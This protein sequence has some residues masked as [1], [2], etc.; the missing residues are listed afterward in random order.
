[1]FTKLTLAD[2]QQYINDQIEENHRLEYKAAGSLVKTDKARREITKDVSAMANADGGLVIY[3]VSEHPEY[4]HLPEK[5]DP[6]DRAQISKE[7]LEHNINNIQPPI[8]GVEVYPIPVS[9]DDPNLAIYVVEI[10]QSDTAHQATDCKYYYRFNFE[11]EPMTD[12]QVRDVMGR[13]KHPKIELSFQFRTSRISLFTRHNLLIT[14]HNCGRIYAQHVSCIVH[15]PM[16]LSTREIEPF[17]RDLTIIDGQQ[18]RT[19]QDVNTH[20]D[21]IEQWVND[22]DYQPR[23]YHSLGPSWFRPI[24]PKMSHQWVH[25]LPAKFSYTDLPSDE[26]IHWE[27]YADNALPERGSTSLKTIPIHIEEETTKSVVTRGL[28][29]GYDQSLRLLIVIGV[30]LVV[31]WLIV[32]VFKL[33]TDLTS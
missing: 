24:L 11:A 31:F 10:P 16:S 3:G 1:M 26:H 15:L 5:I 28:R 9:I 33:I 32:S 6:V 30:S 12:T 20:R 29:R 19:I 25:S 22:G 2:I 8:R 4:R 23:K 7:W 13:S 18:Y 27:V 17:D 21:T 14:A